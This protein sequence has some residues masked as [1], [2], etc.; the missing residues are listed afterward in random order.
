MS[1]G[2]KQSGFARL[3]CSV[4]TVRNKLKLLRQTGQIC[5]LAKPL[6]TIDQSPWGLNTCSQI[7]RRSLDPAKWFFECRGGWGV[8]ETRLHDKHIPVGTLNQEV[9]K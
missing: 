6:K 2:R 5:G 7:R 3:K 4:A 1:D 9:F 8:G